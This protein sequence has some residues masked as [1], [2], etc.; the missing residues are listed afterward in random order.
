MISA[1]T[2][3]AQQ[4]INKMPGEEIT[5]NGKSILIQEVE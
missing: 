1:V 5:W 4:M 3:L 2:P